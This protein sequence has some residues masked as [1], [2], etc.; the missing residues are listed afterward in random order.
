[1]D[2]MSKYHFLRSL[3]ENVQTFVFLIPCE[4]SSGQTGQSL[5]LENLGLG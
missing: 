1:M 4:A 2:D 5:E 3:E